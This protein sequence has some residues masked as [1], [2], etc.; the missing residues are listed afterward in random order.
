MY[1]LYYY[2]HYCYYYYFSGTSSSCS[3]NSCSTSSSTSSSSCIRYTT[4][5]PRTTNISTTTLQLLFFFFFSIL[6]RMGKNKALAHHTSTYFRTR[7]VSILLSCFRS[8]TLA[9]APFGSHCRY[10]VSCPY[11]WSWL[12]TFLFWC[13]VM[14]VGAY[15]VFKP[16]NNGTARNVSWYDIIKIKIHSSCEIEDFVETHLCKL[17]VILRSRY[18]II[19]EILSF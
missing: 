1:W 9:G 19:F 18:C 4:Y 12:L 17:C 10:S 7:R 8:P 15:L 3:T 14:Q 16:L 11:Q 13:S 6:R 2:W 5:T